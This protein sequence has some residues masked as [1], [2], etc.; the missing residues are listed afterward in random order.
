MQ[1]FKIPDYLHF[2]EGMSNGTSVV[3]AGISSGAFYGLV[4]GLGIPL[5]ALLV[6]AVAFFLLAKR[7]VPLSSDPPEHE[8]AASALADG[9]FTVS[10]PPL[11]S[12]SGNIMS[13]RRVLDTSM[14]AS[15]PP[16]N[17]SATS[18]RVE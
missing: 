8:I 9:A 13:P 15:A 6:A 17:A 5:G 2:H 3:P 4:F 12:S 1:L 14:R 7:N 18:S 11:G 10:R 16:I